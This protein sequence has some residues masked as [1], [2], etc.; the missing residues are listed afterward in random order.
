M[1]L[2]N[3]ARENYNKLVSPLG[4]MCL[5]YIEYKE[6]IVNNGSSLL[7]VMEKLNVFK[8]RRW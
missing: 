7:Q 1:Q 4:T 5:R 8:R 6:Q 3:L 2:L